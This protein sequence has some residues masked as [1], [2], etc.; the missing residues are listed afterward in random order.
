MK[1]ILA[2]LLTFVCVFSF[3]VNALAEEEQ[4]ANIVDPINSGF[5]EAETVEDTAWF[6]LL[7]SFGD[8]RKKS[9]TDMEIKTG[10]AHSGVKYLST[11]GTK[12]WHSTAINLHPFFVEAGSGEY[13]ISFYFRCKEKNIKT[14]TVICRECHRINKCCILA[15][16]LVK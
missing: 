1:K 4:S 7:D 8:S 12:S 13:M 2:I 6:K 10:G 3:F 5:E 16:Y 9:Y 15:L 14:F 11:K